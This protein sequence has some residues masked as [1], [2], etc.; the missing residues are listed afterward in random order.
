[1]ST[2]NVE[3]RYLDVGG[4]RYVHLDDLIILFSDI[5]DAKKR[6]EEIDGHAIVQLLKDLRKAP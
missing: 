5:E 3:L 1:M 2:V 4:N 6:N